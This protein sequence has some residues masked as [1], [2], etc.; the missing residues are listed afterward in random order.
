MR[1]IGRAS[2]AVVIGALAVGGLAPSVVAAQPSRAEGLVKA[3]VT[4]HAEPTAAQMKAMRGAGARVTQRYGLINGAAVE[5]PRN[6]IANLRRQRGVATV[7]LDHTVVAFDHPAASSH[8]EYDNAWGVEHI[9]AAAV[10]AAGIDGTSVKVA[11]I[12][13]GLDYVHDDPDDTPYNVDPEFLGNY[14]GGY[15]FINDDADPMDDNGHGTHVA[16]SLAAERNNYLVAGVAPGIDLYALKILNAAGEGDVSDLILALQWAV[17]NDIDVVNMSLG[18]HEVSPALASAVANAHAAGLLMVAASGNTVTFQE[19]LYGC[20]VAYP[21]AYPEVLS[22]TFTNGNN[23]LTGYSCTGP[24]VDFAS[25]GDAIISTVPIGPCM[26][27]SPQGYASQ[28]GTSMASPHLAGSVALLLDAGL[29]D[30]EGDGL[31]DDVR[32]QLCATADQGFGVLST[33]IPPTDPRYPKFFG[34]GVIDAD[35]AVLSLDPGPTNTPPVAAA[36]E[37]T[38]DEDRSVDIDVIANDS[39]ADGD[40]PAVSSIGTPANGSASLNAA[41]LVRYVPEPNFAGNDSF[42]YTISDGRG[43]SDTASVKVRVSAINDAPV[44]T[45]DVAQTNEDLAIDVAVLAN[46]SDIDGVALSVASVG[47]AVNGSP[48]INGDGTVHFVPASNFAGDAYF[49]Y[50]V[51]DGAGGS[52]VGRVFVSVEPVNDPPVAVDDGA[53]TGAGV[54]VTI[55]VLENDTDVEGSALSVAGVSD[56]PNGSVVSNPDGTVTYTPDPGFAGTDAF[57]YTASDGSAVSGLATVTVTV[58][59]PPPANPIHVGDLDASTGG[60]GGKWTA[61]VNVRIEGSTHAA[62]AGA[63]VTGTWSDGAT[64]TVTCTT[65]SGGRCTVKKQG[66]SRATIA[67]VRFTVTS[68]TIA[69]RT[70]VPSSNHDADGDSDGTTIV[71]LRPV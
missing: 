67:S 62:V 22:T 32:G 31:L 63:L 70:Y 44:A 65:G 46:D 37:A 33:P 5:V 59:P 50:T 6:A 45:D 28:S 48:S 58:A 41:G 42:D 30:P 14:A 24:E 40:Q 9:G 54:A 18:T 4:F 8:F 17:D 2:F 7:E 61:K 66:L 49:E 3:I 13:T 47:T 57:A 71:V 39:D 68:V 34:C 64:G 12:D 43:G 56:P 27:C 11:V 20:P 10:H 1:S 51:S 21:G 29:S 23:A 16:G 69:G 35:G 36:D 25:P 19:L 26:F 55:G 53:A 38:V 15:D 52:D 60:S